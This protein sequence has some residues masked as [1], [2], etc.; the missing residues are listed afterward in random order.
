MVLN[1]ALLACVMLDVSRSLPLQMIAWQPS[2]GAVL[3][4]PVH[5]VCSNSPRVNSDAASIAASSASGLNEVNGGL[6]A[7]FCHN[8]VA[9]CSV[10]FAGELVSAL[11]GIDFNVQVKAIGDAIRGKCPGWTWASLRH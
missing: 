1:P 2:T 6:R 5:C 11:G 4:R 8:R 10:H 7:W 9:V 3:S